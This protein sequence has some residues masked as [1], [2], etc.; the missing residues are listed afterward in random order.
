MDKRKW[1]VSFLAALLVLAMMFGFVVSF[2]P[3]MTVPVEAAKSSSA[4]K[5]EI[6]ELEK[7]K[8][9]AQDKLNA[10]KLE[11]DQHAGE[12]EK[13]KAEKAY[14]DQ[15]VAYLSQQ[16]SAI[17]E[18]ITSY[19]KMIAE[20]H[21]ELRAAEKELT[22]LQAKNKERLR[23]ME[24]HGKLS[25]WS[26]IFKANN[27]SDLLDRL[28]MVNEIQENDKKCIEQICVA[29]ETVSQAKEEL[30]KSKAELVV[31]EAQLTAAQAELAPKQ[32]EADRLLGEMIAKDEEFREMKEKA[33]ESLS[34][35]KLEILDKEEQ[36]DAA[37]EREYQEWLQAQQSQNNQNDGRPNTVD[38][39][40]WVVPINYTYF[41]S[42]YGMRMHPVYG[43]WR[44]HHGVDLSAPTGTP[45]IASRSGVINSV[46]FE[47]GGAGNYVNI[48]HKDG[49][50]TRYMHMT[51]YIVAPGQYVYAG[52]VIGYCGSTGASTGPH[53]HFGIY[54]NGASVD[55]ALY[56]DI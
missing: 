44:M 30:E 15:Q 24:K 14:I 31:V 42:P 54:Y 4:I 3:V 45:I 20:K 21:T 55:P 9:E 16:I 47:A 10:L 49:F 12:F 6:Q 48:D 19:N 56:I 26:V 38:G 23:A 17:N 37:K 41:S 39:V 50:V 13:I 34:Q 51:H 2:L 52:Q 22:A 27:F 1:I 43:G 46:G 32:A 11:M 53:L 25:Y 5:Q 36:Y 8:Q 33:E 29:M 40:T 28:K 7:K 35:V 18:Q